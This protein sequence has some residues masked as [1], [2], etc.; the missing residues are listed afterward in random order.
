MLLQL[1]EI[2]RPHHNAHCL[3]GTVSQQMYIRVSPSSGVLG[4][5]SC[6]FTTLQYQ[7]YYH[8]LNTILV[9]LIE[10]G[11]TATSG[12]LV[13]RVPITKKN[14]YF[15]THLSKTTYNDNTTL[16]VIVTKVVVRMKHFVNL[17][18]LSDFCKSRCTLCIYYL[19]LY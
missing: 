9:K 15:N 12:Y 13:P 10:K 18:Y 3:I 17:L 14:I 6:L 16:S 19:Y 5:I 11:T 2:G 8:K 7:N 4:L 1:I